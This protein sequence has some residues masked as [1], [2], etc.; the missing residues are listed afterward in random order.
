VTAKEELLELISS[1][2]EEEAAFLLQGMRRRQ[3]EVDNTSPSYPSY[4]RLIEERLAAMDPVLLEETPTDLAEQHDHYA[5]GT[6]K[7]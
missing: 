4:L 1:M 5:Y 6:P 3:T 2:P 7:K